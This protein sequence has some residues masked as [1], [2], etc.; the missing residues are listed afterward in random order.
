MLH[1]LSLKKKK[2]RKKRDKPTKT[3][4]KGGSKGHKCPWVIKGTEKLPGCPPIGSL[5]LGYPQNA[6]SFPCCRDSFSQYCRWP[7][8]R[9]HGVRT[10]EVVFSYLRLENSKEGSYCLG[11]YYCSSMCL[12][13]ATPDSPISSKQREEHFP[14][15]RLYCQ[16]Q[17]RVAM[18]KRDNKV[19]GEKKNFVGRP[20]IYFPAHQCVQK[21]VHT[22][23]HAHLLIPF[24]LTG[25]SFT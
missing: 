5:S 23:A 3:K 21:C 11:L 1:V 25:F 19:V 16:E 6:I 9:S 4:A 14:K 22:H 7:Q 12:W 15:R 10:Q 18:G 24:P 17:K 2:T 20:L 8:V 13:W